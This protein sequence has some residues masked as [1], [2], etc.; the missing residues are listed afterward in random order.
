MEQVKCALKPYGLFYP[1]WHY[2]HTIYQKDDKGEL[3]LLENKIVPQ[4][5]RR[6]ISAEKLEK[7]KE[8]VFV[9]SGAYTV[10]DYVESDAIKAEYQEKMRK[11]DR[12]CCNLCNTDFTIKE[13]HLRHLA[14]KQ[15]IKQRSKKLIEYSAHTDKKILDLYDIYHT[16]NICK[17]IKKEEN[18]GICI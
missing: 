1:D 10:E 4:F 8:Y 11:Y 14:T 3:V 18:F 9:K 5:L 15:H 16:S 13:N 6:P 7:M 12:Y 17:I 2:K